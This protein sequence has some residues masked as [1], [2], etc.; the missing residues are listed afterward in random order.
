VLDFMRLLWSIEHGLQSTSKR[1][2][3]RLGIT[4]PQRLV[5][6]M[7]HRFPG[8]LAGELAHTLR[9]DPGTI[10]GIVQRLVDKRLIVR[11]RDSADGRRV[12]L[13]IGEKARRFTRPTSGTIE[14]AVKKAL[15]R[16][17]AAHVLH[18]RD[19]LRAV[20]DALEDV[21]HG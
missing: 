6:K 13:R 19:V 8:I 15:R 3:A 2:T 12:H 16:K 11:E 7:V 4:G 9:L 1:M 20:A 21:S 10:S 17:P 18:S 5:L 14:A